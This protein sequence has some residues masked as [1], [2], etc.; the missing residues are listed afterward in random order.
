MTEAAERAGE[1]LDSGDMAGAETWHQ[2]L[3]AIERLPAQRPAEDEARGAR[4]IHWEEAKMV[5]RFALTG[6]LAIALTATSYVAHAGAQ[7]EIGRYQVVM[8]NDRAGHLAVLIDTVTGRSWILN[9]SNDRRWSELNYGEMKG[10]HLLLMPA[11]CAQDNPSCFF[12]SSKSE[13]ESPAAQ[14]PSA[15][16]AAH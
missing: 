11:P 4:A 15:D 2:I 10:G 8:I 3:G 5:V 12:G 6:A 13:G 14:K 16:E 7:V 9:A 1:W